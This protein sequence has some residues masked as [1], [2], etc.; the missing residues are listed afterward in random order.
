MKTVF[1]ILIMAVA[2][3]SLAKRSAPKPVPSIRYKGIVYSVIHW[4]SENGTGQNGGYIEARD[5]RSKKKIWGC[6]VYRI[7]KTAGLEGDV[8]DVFITNLRIDKKKRVLIVIN[9]IGEIFH[10]NIKTRKVSRILTKGK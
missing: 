5:K 7:K 9:E 8:Q 6:V 3:I 1:V 2:S 10:V 4:S